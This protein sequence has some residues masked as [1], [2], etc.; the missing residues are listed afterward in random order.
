[1]NTRVLAVDSN[2]KMTR[3]ARNADILELSTQL[4]QDNKKTFVEQS[5]NEGDKSPL[6]QNSK[7]RRSRRQG[8][9]GKSRDRKMEPS[10]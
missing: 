6:L 2:S 5:S 4:I 1:M 10:E 8:S 7:R 9:L 3:A